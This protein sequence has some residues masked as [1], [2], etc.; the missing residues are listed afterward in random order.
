MREFTDNE[1]PGSVNVSALRADVVRMHDVSSGTM[2]IYK[3]AFDLAVEM[4]GD[5]PLRSIT[6]RDVDAYRSARLLKVKPN[7]VISEMAKLRAAFRLA[8]RWNYIERSPFERCIMPVVPESYPLFFT[9]EQFDK[10]V[11][12]ENMEYYKGVYVF[13]VNT[14]L[15][16]GEL[17][18]LLRD[19][20]DAERRII[21]VISTETHRTKT[22]TSRKVPMN[23]AVMDVVRGLQR[24]S[25]YLLSNH[26]RHMAADTLYQRFKKRIRE[27]ELDDRFHFH[28][29]RHTF[30]SWLVQAGVDIYRVKE[31]LG[32]SD[33][34]TTMIYAHLRPS[35]LHDAVSVLDK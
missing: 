25:E 16:Q 30:A 22:R 33:I 10:V 11:S 26:G 28:T 2:D 20:V 12:L 34:Q 21:T 3:H 17:I 35:D 4:F 1:Q 18:H 8:V 7:T 31:L 19:N 9:R 15:R 14:G 24:D 23:D 29:L 27:A 6:Q 13:A 5:V 32:H